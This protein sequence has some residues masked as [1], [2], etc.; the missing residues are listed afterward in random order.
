MKAFWAFL[1]RKSLP[2]TSLGKLCHAVFG[3]GDS[4]YQQ[5]NSTAKKL[6]RRLT[7]LGSRELLERG[8]GDDQHFAGYDA[9]LDPW[10]QELWPA[11]SRVW[12]QQCHDLIPGTNLQPQLCMSV[13]H[14]PNGNGHALPMF[15]LMG[16]DHAYG[17]LRKLCCHSECCMN[18]PFGF[19]CCGLCCLYAHVPT[20]ELYRAGCGCRKR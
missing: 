16:V 18:V 19:A 12:P 13:V 6:N 3:L 20:L 1:L 10:L 7:A 4:G 8:L 14:V 5:Y 2:P 17:K 9:A 11:L 15:A